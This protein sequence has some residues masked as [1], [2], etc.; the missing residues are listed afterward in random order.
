M[1]LQVIKAFIP[2]D[3][4]MKSESVKG[5]DGKN[6]EKMT[7]AGVASTTD[8]DA[9]GE[10][11]DP[12]GMELQ[13]FLQKGH[14]NWEHLGHYDPSAIIGYPVGAEIKDD[15]LHIK[16]ELYPENEI[17]VKA[18]KLMK[19]MN[20]AGKRQM[21]FSIEAHV[22]KRKDDDKTYV[23]KSM[24]TDIALTP[25]PKN[26]STNAIIVKSFNSL[27]EA[28]DFKFH[29]E[30]VD[31]D[32][33]LS[34]LEEINKSMGGAPIDGEINAIIELAEAV[35]AGEISDRELIGIKA[36]VISNKQLMDKLEKELA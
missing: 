10:V 6:I 5:E 24:V 17:A 31:W 22:I 11:I 8:R 19:A 1:E 27:T 15:K 26:F 9:D 32:V 20:K 2:A 28:N 16:A 21:G 7:I 30:N 29:N 36:G 14:I 12:N 34:E 33:E 4:V 18:F 23:E 3:L 25:C 13:Y 35:S